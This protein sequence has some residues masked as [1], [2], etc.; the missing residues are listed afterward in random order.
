MSPHLTQVE[1]VVPLIGKLYA[2][3][4]SV[5][6]FLAAFEDRKLTLAMPIG[7]AASEVAGAILCLCLRDSC[8]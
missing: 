2:A 3:G 6:H 8:V 7:D 1:T 4:M 5:G